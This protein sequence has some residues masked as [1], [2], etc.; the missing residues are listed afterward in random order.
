MNKPIKK[1]KVTYYLPKE[2]TEYLY[3]EAMR[4]DQ[5][6]SYTLTEIVH[7]HSE[8]IKSLTNSPGNPLD[9]TKPQHEP[10]PWPVR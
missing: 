3:A 2:V 8:K 10:F 6:V 4:K 5:S 1:I 7:Q 9:E